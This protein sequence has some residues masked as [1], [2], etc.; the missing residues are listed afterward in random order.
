VGAAPRRRRRRASKGRIGLLFGTHF[1]VV[2]FGSAIA[3]LV[4]VLVALSH[5]H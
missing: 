3:L 5:I 1:A 4:I 2:F